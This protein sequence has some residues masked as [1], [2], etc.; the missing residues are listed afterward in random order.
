MIATTALESV[1]AER[2]RQDAKWDEQNNDPFC[3]ITVLGE[4][5]GELCQ[6]ALHAR[7]G[8][9]AA[10]KLREEAVHTAAVALAIVECLDRGK[11]AWPLDT[12]PR[13]GTCGVCGEPIKFI[14]PQWFHASDEQPRHLATPR[15]VS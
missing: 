6:A 9:P 15:E 2:E 7:F 13:L 14:G 5:F 10:T 3:Y 4:E 8:G 11:W 1:L 12:T